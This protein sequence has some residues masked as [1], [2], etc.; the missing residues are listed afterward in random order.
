MNAKYRSLFSASLLVCAL[1]AA[2]GAHALVI[3]A[4]NYKVG[5]NL[6]DAFPGVTLQYAQHPIGSGPGFT[7]SPLVVGTD[8]DYE[9]TPLYETLSPTNGGDPGR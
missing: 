4:S 6:S 1:L 7:T 5:T 8:A 2:P 3:K 9:L